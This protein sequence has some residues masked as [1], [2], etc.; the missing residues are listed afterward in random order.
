MTKTIF[1]TYTKQDFDMDDFIR[2]LISAI[3]LTTKNSK[4]LIT[5]I[6]S[7]HDLSTY[8]ETIKFSLHQHRDDEHLYDYEI[9]FKG[10]FINLTIKFTTTAFILRLTEQL[11]EIS[12]T[13]YPHI[14]ITIKPLLE[15]GGEE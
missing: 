2:F 6:N 1:R 3:P 13:H 9:T 15:K 12:T 8:T 5:L 7:H 11:K 4:A 10:E 14:N